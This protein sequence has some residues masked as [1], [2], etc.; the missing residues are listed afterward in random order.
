[1]DFLDFIYFNSIGKS[2]KQ[3]MK[4]YNKIK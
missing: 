1:M 2:T 3:S 4:C